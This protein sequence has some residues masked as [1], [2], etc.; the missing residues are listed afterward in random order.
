M[1]LTFAQ[2]LSEMQEFTGEISRK[3]G[4]MAT[5]FQRLHLCT[6]GNGWFLLSPSQF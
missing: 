3:L 2:D 4:H 5:D 6:G 1:P